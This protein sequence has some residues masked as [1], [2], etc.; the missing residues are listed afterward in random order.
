LLIPLGYSNAVEAQM[1]NVIGLISSANF[2]V[3]DSGIV[4]ISPASDTELPYYVAASGESV[5]TAT[6]TVNI[7]IS[8]SSRCSDTMNVTVTPPG[9]WWQ[10]QDADI[11]SNGNLNSLISYSCTLPVCNPFLEING[12]GGYPGIP[13]ASGTISIGDFANISSTNWNSL[14]ALGL[15]KNYSYSFFERLI[16]SN[17]QFTNLSSNLVEGDVFSLPTLF[18]N[19]AYWFKF[20][21]ASSGQ[22]LT[23]NSDIDVGSNKVVLLVDSANLYINGK[24]LLD[25]G[26]G[27][28]MAIVGK[29]ANGDKG[30]IFINSN[31][32][33]TF[34]YDPEIEGI[35][36]ADGQIDTG[37][38][39][40]QLHLRG[41]FVGM[42]GVNL[43]RDLTDNSITPSEFIEFGPD[44]LFTMPNEL[45]STTINWTE[46]Q[47]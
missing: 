17:T 3:D 33:G 47:P 11:Y 44:L 25:D 27:F 31:V 9:P 12:T 13:I 26:S 38:G 24:I 29:N 5:G 21:G 14:T 34:D 4:S 43:Q 23:I 45:K 36:F 28:F 19:G 32:S 46:I 16:S 6:V 39:T 22:D 2:S 41:S 15:R 8:G 18:S 10:V 1:D 42:D 35:F 20:D 40:E 7:V 30:N 37:I